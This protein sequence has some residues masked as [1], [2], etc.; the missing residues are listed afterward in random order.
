M[1]TITKRGKH[2][3]QAKIRRK[4]LPRALTGTFATEKEAAAWATEVEAQLNKGQHTLVF[5]S[6][7][8]SKMT[9]AEALKKYLTQKTPLKQSWRNEQTMIRMWQRDALAS[10]A[11]T[12]LDSGD[13]AQWRDA[14]L[15]TVSNRTG[16]PVALATV[17]KEL[18]IISQVFNTARTEWKLKGLPNPLA[19]VKKPPAWAK[20]RKER[21]KDPQLRER[22]F[23]AMQQ[24]NK[25]TNQSNQ[26]KRFYAI[27]AMQFA[28]E[29]GMRRGELCKL[30][31]SH[32]HLK[33]CYLEVDRPEHEN[34]RLKG[35]D[36]EV[37]LSKAAIVILKSL[38]KNPQ[39]DQRV[40]P[41]APSTLTKAVRE[42]RR[43]AGLPEYI[44]VHITRHEATSAFRERG[45]SMEETAEMTG[46]TS[47]DTMRRYTHPERSATL[48]KLR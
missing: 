41:I 40:F 7:E 3:W 38:P 1:A 23:E 42:S 48:K 26:A 15:K 39:T 25:F 19:E 47:F 17:R 31:W 5:A 12:A 35:G 33:E 28:L 13:F 45:L 37:L 36:R 2:Q 46:H 18:N 44:N 11:L 4:G 8:A 30:L 34:A 9:L 16:K 32:V 43:A 14:R 24:Q 21:F 22:L 10:K 27:K 29:T 20:P 6:K